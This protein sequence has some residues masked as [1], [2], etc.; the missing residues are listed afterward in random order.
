MT[1]GNVIIVVVHTLV[2]MV[3]NALA[4][5]VTVCLDLEDLTVPQNTIVQVVWYL[6]DNQ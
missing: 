1:H 2:K 6:Q 4:D 3:V 5:I